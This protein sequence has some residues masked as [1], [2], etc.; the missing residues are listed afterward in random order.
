MAGSRAGQGWTMDS[1]NRARSMPLRM[2]THLAA[3]KPR[4]TRLSR[5]PSETPMQA[6]VKGIK[7]WDW[8]RRLAV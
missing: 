8:A 2:A 6:S 3:S 7:A 4:A 5:T 1:G